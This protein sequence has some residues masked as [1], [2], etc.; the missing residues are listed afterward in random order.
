MRQ[1]HDEARF[2][3]ARR[4]RTILA[5]VIIFILIPFT[6][7]F[8]IKFLNDRKYLLISILIIVY[9]MIPF[10]MVFE[11]RKP[12]VR[13]MVIIALM[14]ALTVCGNMACYMI[15]PFQAGTAIVM[16]SGICFGPEAGFLIGA[17]ARFTCNFFQGQGPWTP[18]QMFCWGIIGFISGVI[19]NKAKLHKSKSRS[20][21]IIVGPILS[22]GITLAIAFVIHKI[23]GSGTFLGWQLYAFGALGIIIGLGVQRK[24][25]PI[26]DITLTLY[27]FF[28]TF[29]VYGGIM[30]I[31]AM[32]MAS[33]IPGSGVTLS[34]KSL[35]ILY[36]SGVPYDTVHSLGTAFFMFWIG[37]KLIQKLERVKIK[38]GIY[39]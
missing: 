21:Q 14:S 8:G 15:Q 6:I 29:I 5:S 30:N 24:R 36:I 27:G 35:F 39:G 12:K 13:E 20:F 10:F 28:I 26:D 23:W 32:V 37:E 38:Y 16:I 33:D 18:W 17:L 2:A 25:L 22:I 4:K 7:F 3:G 34:L 11:K 19:F 31:A 9:I 1:K